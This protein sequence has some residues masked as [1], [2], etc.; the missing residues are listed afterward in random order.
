[1]FALHWS[2]L[3]SKARLQWRVSPGPKGPVVVSPQS[4]LYASEVMAD[5][6]TVGLKELI[7]T[8][9]ENPEWVPRL[10]EDIA[11]GI[12]EELPD[13][14]S[15]E[16]LQ[17]A[18][19][20]SAESNVRLIVDMLRGGLEPEHAEPPPAAVE[21][22][23][24]FVRRGLSLDALLRTYFIGHA[25]FFHFVAR[26][27]HKEVREPTALAAT[28][29]E[30]AEWSFAYVQAVTR[31]MAARYGDERER[32]VRSAAA[33]RSESV[34]ALLEGEG[35]D[36]ETASRQL[37]YELDRWH[38]AF[39]VWGDD[40]DEAGTRD[41]AVLERAAFELGSSLG[42]S[43]PLLVPRA[44]LLLGCWLG[45]RDSFDD[46]ALDG[47]RFDVKEFPGISAAF[48]SAVEGVDGF[49][50]SHFEAM[51]ARRVARLARHAPGAVTLY[52]DVALP[53][54]ASADIEHAR[55][56][57]TSELG[58]LAA[59]DDTARRLAATLRVYLEEN[60]SPRRTA[61]RLGVHENTV[62]NRI[63]AAQEMLDRPIE[64]RASELLVALRLERLVRETGA[65]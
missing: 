28:I 63:R 38:L 13:L 39:V 23:R 31:S 60:A 8:A 11:A 54:L 44:P 41:L 52:S 5:Q 7:T 49:R 62:V 29:E 34:R 17:R 16:D 10:T 33:V 59:D 55:I 45:F 22:A 53:A 2:Y 50:Q 58:P 25:R 42:F 1:M 65:I 48:G 19:H 43:S 12:V 64:A 20:A 14:S 61:H 9:A 40:Q 56:F 26:H 18:L 30:L 32:W 27:A 51:H 15:D 47:L 24:E 3:F 6:A 35:L 4:W 36:P 57:V 21:Y 46:A 37:R